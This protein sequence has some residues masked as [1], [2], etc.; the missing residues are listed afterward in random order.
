[1]CRD[2]ALAN[3][4]LANLVAAIDFCDGVTTGL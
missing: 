2:L 4:V 1:M 3:L